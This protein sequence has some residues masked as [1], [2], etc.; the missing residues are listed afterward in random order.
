M[1]R[2]IRGCS[3]SEFLTKLVIRQ[4][5]CMHIPLENIK[6][7]GRQEERRTNDNKNVRQMVNDTERGE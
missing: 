2:K 7:E 3:G 6:L 1:R 4:L 5:I